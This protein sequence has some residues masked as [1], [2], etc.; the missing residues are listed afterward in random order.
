M[1]NAAAFI[2]DVGQNQ[3]WAAQSLEL[4][5]SQR[6]LTSG[7]M[8]SMGFALPAALGAASV[9]SARPIVVIAGDAG[10]QCNLQELQTVVRNQFP[11]KIVILD[12]GCHGMVRQFQQSFFDRRYQS[13]LWGYSAPDF[14]LLGKA[15]GLET[16][17]ITEPGD[18]PAAIEWLRSTGMRPTLLSVKIDT[19]A[20]A[21]PK[22][23]FGSP[24]TEMEPFAPRRCRFIAPAG[25]SHLTEIH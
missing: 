6:F 12:N 24:I 13:T 16:H 8:G 4:Q 23:A 20:N 21:Y 5:E 18:V 10:F 3:M 25:S 19:Y 2:A 7:G 1:P 11:I 17:A 9:Y 15:Y 14:A 22:V